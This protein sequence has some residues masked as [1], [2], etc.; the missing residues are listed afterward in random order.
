MYLQILKYPKLKLVFERWVEVFVECLGLVV[1]N[2][3]VAP[4]ILTEQVAP[5]IRILTSFCSKILR[6]VQ[7]DSETAIVVV[8]L[9]NKSCKSAN[10][11]FPY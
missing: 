3:E 8:N 1:S 11:Y 9:R 4:T 10:K 6:R 7:K 5:G 2:L